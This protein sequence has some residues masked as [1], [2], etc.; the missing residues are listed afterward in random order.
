M[1]VV[2]GTQVDCGNYDITFFANDISL[3]T[4]SNPDPTVPVFHDKRTGSIPNEFQILQ[5]SNTSL[6]LLWDITFT[7]KLVDYPSV[8]AT[9]IAAQSFAINV[10]DPCKVPL[11]TFTPN[12]ITDMSY[13]LLQPNVTLPMETFT[14]SSD[15]CIRSYTYVADDVTIYDAIL[16]D[17]TPTAP[18]FTYG[19]TTDLQISPTQYMLADAIIYKDYIITIT[20]VSETINVSTTFTLTINNPCVD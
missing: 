8:T 5:T 10:R 16:F 13:T 18:S 11:L 12:P 20:G 3:L 19:F 14:I 2:S 17:D 6:A 15:W 9:S 4:D 1:V 7:V